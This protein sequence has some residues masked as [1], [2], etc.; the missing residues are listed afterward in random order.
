MGPYG[1]SFIGFTTRGVSFTCALRT[2]RVPAA[3]EA[4]KPFAWG[5]QETHAGTGFKPRGL[6]SCVNRRVLSAPC[7][8]EHTIPPLGTC[9]NASFTA[10][11]FIC[12][13]VPSRSTNNPSAYLQQM[14]KHRCDYERHCGPQSWA[15]YVGS[16]LVPSTNVVMA[17]PGPSRM[18]PHTFD[19]Q[20]PISAT[21][22]PTLGM[23]SIG[24]TTD[25]ESA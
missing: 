11:D 16:D 22:I 18:S 3:H 24:H 8:S 2:V 10:L 4:D 15:I 23:H 6:S 1:P 9:A 7:S 12:H 20:R 13:E 25:H 21:T 17:Y 19:L 14:T 5:R